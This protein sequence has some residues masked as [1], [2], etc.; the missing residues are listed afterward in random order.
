MA[1]SISDSSLL[2]NRVCLFCFFFVLWVASWLRYIYCLSK[3][4]GMDTEMI[5]N[6]KRH[7]LRKVLSRSSSL[8]VSIKNPYLN[9]SLVW[10]FTSKHSIMCDWTWGLLGQE[11][12]LYMII[13]VI[14]GMKR[15]NFDFDWPFYILLYTILVMSPRSTI[16][17]A[18]DVI[19]TGLFST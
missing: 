1:D 3:L 9:G 5:W 2:G 6:I 13:L 19:S 10:R 15:E 17:R 18:R 8:L 4:Y 11:P 7:L 16:W 12:T 14:A